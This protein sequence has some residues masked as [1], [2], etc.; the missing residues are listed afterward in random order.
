MMMK[1]ATSHYTSGGGPP[2]LFLGH[3][4]NKVNDIIEPVCE[5]YCGYKFL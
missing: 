3:I 1:F 4:N 2:N 5:G